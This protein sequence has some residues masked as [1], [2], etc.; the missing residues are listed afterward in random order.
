MHGGRALRTLYLFTASDFKTIM[1]PVVCL[2]F[3]TSI[4]Y[5]SAL[6]HSPDRLRLRCRAYYIIFVVRSCRRVALVAFAPMQ[7]LKPV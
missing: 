2:C 1:L 5:L 6:N 7:R 4:I 3:N